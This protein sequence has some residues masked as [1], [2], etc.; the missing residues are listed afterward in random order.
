MFLTI[1]KP[2]DY[3]PT[4]YM[5]QWF[6]ISILITTLGI[7]E[8]SLTLLGARFGGAQHWKTETYEWCAYEMQSSNKWQTDYRLIR[9]VKRGHELLKRL[10]TRC[11]LDWIGTKQKQ[12]CTSWQ[13][14]RTNTWPQK[15][16]K[17]NQ[18]E[19]E[20]ASWEA[21]S[22]VTKLKALPLRKNYWQQEG[23]HGRSISKNS[24]S[25]CDGEID[26]FREAPFT[27]NSKSTI[28]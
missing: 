21:C 3:R 2:S 19:P 8:H 13:Y 6:N 24:Y 5:V 11:T 23:V 18:Q 16:L 1:I 9:G 7:N 14:A 15:S 26:R 10:S 22:T 4:C 12:A 28:K 27:A 17:W 25:V 20:S